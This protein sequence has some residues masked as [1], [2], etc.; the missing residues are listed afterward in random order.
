M[1]MRYSFFSFFGVGTWGNTIN[2]SLILA[3]EIIP[4]EEM[5]NCTLPQSFL[6]F[7]IFLWDYKY[8]IMGR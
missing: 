8:T 2:F 7:T 1:K 5:Q 6:F 4:V 3:R